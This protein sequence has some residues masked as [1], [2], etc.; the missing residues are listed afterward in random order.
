VYGGF[1][2]VTKAVRC[3]GCPT[4]TN[5]YITVTVS[6]TGN[7]LPATITKTTIIAAF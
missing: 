2:R 1:T 5:D 3:S 4:A 7:N 6:V